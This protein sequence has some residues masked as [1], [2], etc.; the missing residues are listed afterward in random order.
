MADVFSKEVRSEVMSKIK[1]KDTT[2][3][4]KLRKE[5]WARGYRYRIHYKLPGKPDIVFV[6][7]RIA[8]FVDG[9]FWHKCPKCYIKP[10]S[11]KKYWLPKIEKNV[12]RDKKNTK[13]LENK[14]WK[15]IRIWEHEIKK[16]FIVVI[17]RI[18]SEHENKLDGT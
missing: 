16:D 14:G 15:V 12:E 8:I 11:N 6:G 18:M 10:K 7:K 2:P 4:M 13:L 5:L 3:E 9:C 1:S 17:D